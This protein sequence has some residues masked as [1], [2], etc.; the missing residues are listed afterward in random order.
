MYLCLLLLLGAC[1]GAL[2]AMGATQFAKDNWAYLDNGQIRLGL[3]KSAGGCIGFLSES[4]TNWNLLNHFDRGRFVQQSYYG[5]ADGTLW[6]KKPW[7]WNPVQGGD[8]K[9]TPAKLLAS[10]IESQTA[11]TKTQARHWSGCVDLPECSLEQ[12]INLTGRVAHVRFKMTYTGTVAHPETHHE[13]PALFMDPGLSTLIQYDGEKPWTRGALSR[14]VPGWPNEGRSITE[15]WAAFVDSHDFG[16]G[17]YV[18]VS[19]KITTYRFG[20]GG[21]E[22]GAC[23]YF[24]PLVSFAITP[25]KTFEYDLYLVV[26]RSEEIRDE[27]YRIHAQRT[28]ADAPA[29]K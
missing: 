14:S 11:Y 25:G 15:N 10:Q 17:A 18:P 24:A 29:S 2:Q 23:S 7:R 1:V 12:W 20:K 27:I 19:S 26:G 9:G 4:R 22:Q 8:Y 5:R 3:N 13:V 6:A 21:A 16:V 28:N